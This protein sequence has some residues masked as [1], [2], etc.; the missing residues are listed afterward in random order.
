MGSPAQLGT[1]RTDWFKSSYSSSTG[2][3]VEVRF[4]GGQVAVRDSKNLH[5]AVTGLK[6]NV[7]AEQWT[8]FKGGIEP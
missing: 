8:A 2:T 6:L 7:T 3:C 1:T 4:D 5:A